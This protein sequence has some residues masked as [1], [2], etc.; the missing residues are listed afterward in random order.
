[1]KI[2][3]KLK[4][5]PVYGDNPFLD[6]EIVAKVK[7]KHHRTGSKNND[8][9]IDKGSGEVKGYIGDSTFVEFKEVD[10]E[11]FT[12]LFLKNLKIFFEL[13]NNDLRVLLY[14]MQMTNP[15]RDMIVISKVDCM[16]YTQIKHRDTINRCLDKLLVNR[17]IA[18]TTV[19]NVYFINPHIFFNGDRL[20]FMKVVKR[21]KENPEEFNKS[22]EIAKNKAIG[23]NLENE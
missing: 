15:N 18:K 19:R 9:V 14:I 23:P 7:K 6:T 2:A 12:K 22:I 16:K 10:E 5:Y 3:T 4:E 11:Q 20:T 21:R 17:I 13:N 1:M 8:L